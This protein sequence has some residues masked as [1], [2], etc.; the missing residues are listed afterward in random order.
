MVGLPPGRIM[1]LSG[2]TSTPVVVARVRRATA[3]RVASRPVAGV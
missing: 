3:S 2:D 1:T